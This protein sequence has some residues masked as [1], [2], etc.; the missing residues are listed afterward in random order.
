MKDIT[1]KEIRA[2]EKVV[3]TTKSTNKY[4][5]SRGLTLGIVRHVTP[6]QCIIE[7]DRGTVTLREES[8]CVALLNW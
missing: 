7:Y 5:A 4:G 2:G 1:G 6:K 8:K 3:F